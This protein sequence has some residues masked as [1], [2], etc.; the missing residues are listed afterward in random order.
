MN[1]RDVI[2]GIL[3]TEE[4]SIVLQNK[5]RIDTANRARIR[6]NCYNC[7]IP[8]HRAVDCRKE[9]G[10]DGQINQKN[11]ENG[12]RGR[13]GADD[14]EGEH[15]QQDQYNDQNEDYGSNQGTY[16]N[17]DDIY[18]VDEQAKRKVTIPGI[19]DIELFKMRD[20]ADRVFESVS[21]HYSEFLDERVLAARAVTALW[22]IDS[23]VT[24]HC[25]GDGQAFESLDPSYKG[26][27]GTASTSRV[28]EH[29]SKFLD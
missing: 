13:S 20:I 25:T 6:G 10:Q 7:E 5:Q 27:L 28:S 26:I 12:Q 11:R 8:G 14:Q 19:R 24:T 21:E 1:E 18:R 4:R 9:K 3:E 29:Y 15:Q 22:N 23:G 17:D 16:I 2:L